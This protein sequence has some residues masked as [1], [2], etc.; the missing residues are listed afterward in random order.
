MGRQEDLKMAAKMRRELSPQAFDML[1]STLLEVM[2]EGAGGDYKQV[3]K[4]ITSSGVMTRGERRILK[5]DLMA[6]AKRKK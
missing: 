4:G 2:L 3:Y 5:R 1:K 6:A